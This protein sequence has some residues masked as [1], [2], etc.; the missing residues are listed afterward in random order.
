MI[1]HAAITAFVVLA[2][3]Q[4]ASSAETCGTLRDKC[5]AVCTPDRVAR[6]HFGSERRCTASCTPRWNACM[7]TG[8]WADLEGVSNHWYAIVDRF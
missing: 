1:R 2:G 3:M 7:A 6:Y 5:E 8:L 4:A